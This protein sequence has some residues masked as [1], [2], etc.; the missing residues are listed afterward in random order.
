MS[1]WD[2]LKPAPSGK[3]KATVKPPTAAELR[4]A[5]AQAKGEA[6][7]T[8]E[9]AAELALARA[10]QLLV[11]TESELDEA[12]RKLQ[13][14]Q[15]A[16]DRSAV[17]VEALTAKLAAAEAAER[18]AELDRVFGEG[19][20]ALDEAISLYKKYEELAKQVAAVVDRIPECRAIVDRVNG[21]LAKAGDARRLPDLDTEAR[22]CV[23]DI[24]QLRTPLWH[25]VVLP[26]GFFPHDYHWPASAELRYKFPPRPLPPQDGAEPP[27]PLR[28]RPAGIAEA[29]DVP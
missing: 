24:Q 9:A 15:R 3:T 22:P 4:E 17:A 6:A 2:F 14:A 8:E 11:G 13:L 19:K 18:Q 10:S 25:Q 7:S 23:S 26:S 5:L 1:F 20:A 21:D 12:D 29:A 16:A 27:P 28:T